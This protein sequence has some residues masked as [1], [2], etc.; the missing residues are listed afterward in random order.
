LI[1]T[2]LVFLVA[3]VCVRLGFWQLD[4]LEQRRERNAALAANMA[5]QPI[6]LTASLVDTAGLR[7]RRALADGTYDGDRSIVL[8]GRSL[9]GVPGVHLL[10][11]L[12]LDGGTAVLVNRGW[13]QAADAATIPDTFFTEHSRAHVNG[14]LISFPSAIASLAPPTSPQ[15]DSAFRR[16]WFAIDDRSLRRQFP[17]RLLNVQLQLLPEPDAPSWP[18]RLPAPMLDP[19]PHMGYAFQ[20]FSFALIAIGGWT[21]MVLRS[22]TARAGIREPRKADTD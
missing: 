19:G 8:P 10:T 7:L 2:V 12:I 5:A 6:Q 4:R 14:I 15:P 13:V 21:A 22:R 16:V 18:I 11:P 3:G 17:Y 20:W 1:A 9:R